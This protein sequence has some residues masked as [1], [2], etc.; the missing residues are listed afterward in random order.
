MT[1]LIT[2]PKQQAAK[3]ATILAE[4][5]IESIIFPTLEIAPPNDFASLKNVVNVLPSFDRL[6]FVSPNT[7][8]S[9]LD[10][11]RETLPHTPL[12][13]ELNIL[14]IGLGTANSLQLAGFKN[15]HYP[16][17]ANSV[18]LLL[19]PELQNVQEKKI[20]IFAGIGGKSLLA[21]TLQQRGAQLTLAFTHQSKL[22]HYT[23]SALS[24]HP[25]DIDLIISTSSISLR[26]LHTI[27]H[28]CNYLDLLKKSLLVISPEMVTAAH[29]L[30]FTGKIIEAAGASDQAII[31]AIMLYFP[32]SPNVIG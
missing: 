19:L 5:G 2:R 7:V 3:L 12:P 18:E 25:T 32:T 9:F 16:Q 4:I 17:I 26:N 24:W 28:D 11:Y 10:F 29:S 6:I 22:P 30:D 23:K 15:I 21:D 1:V 8:S 27:L 13:T 31:S 14:A 20:V